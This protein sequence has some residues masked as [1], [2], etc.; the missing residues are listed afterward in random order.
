MTKDHITGNHFSLLEI[1]LRNVVID[2]FRSIEE[3]TH[4]DY[5]WQKT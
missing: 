5:I 2:L 1:I 4:T 3:L